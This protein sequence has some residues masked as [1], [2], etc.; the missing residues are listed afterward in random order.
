MIQMSKFSH[1]SKNLP[2]T[3]LLM[4][5][6]SVN[7]ITYFTLCDV[8]PATLKLQFSGVSFHF[9]IKSIFIPTSYIIK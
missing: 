4:Q 2:F 7:Y 1:E 3:H 8:E 5:F 9:S 6:L